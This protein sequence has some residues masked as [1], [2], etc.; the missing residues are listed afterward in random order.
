MKKILIFIFLFIL[1]TGL[2]F[3]A[4]VQVWTVPSGHHYTINKGGDYDIVVMTNHAIIQVYDRVGT[5]KNTYNAGESW[6]WVYS[7]KIWTFETEKYIYFI[8]VVKRDNGTAFPCH[9]G[10]M[11]LRYDKTNDTYQYINIWQTGGTTN[12]DWWLK[13][14][15]NNTQIIIE[16]GWLNWPRYFDFDL[17]TY[18]TYTW[19]TPLSPVEINW[20]Y[21]Y[22]ASLNQINYLDEINKEYV[23]YVSDTQGDYIEIR[24]QF[25]SATD[26]TGYTYLYNSD[27][28]T[29]SLSI[30]GEEVGGSLDML[31]A[32]NDYIGNWSIYDSAKFYIKQTQEGLLAVGFPDATYNYSH[33]Q[34]QLNFYPINIAGDDIL[35]FFND[36]WQIMKESDYILPLDPFPWTNWDS[37]TWTLVYDATIWDWDADGDGDVELLNWEI[38]VWIWKMFKYFFEKLLDFFANVR[39]LLEKLGEVFTSEEKTFSLIKTSYATENLSSIINNN[40]DENAYKETTLG[41]IDVFIKWFMAFLILV[42]GIAF[43]IWINRSKSD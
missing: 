24:N 17:G 14:R 28:G 25:I 36:L 5:L 8:N 23:Y 30:Y 32:Y 22:R 31:R 29:I 15:V 18:W 6:S 39:A 27:L 38:F 4:I 9:W 35:Y 2:A 11:S 34:H 21:I 1:S 26:F 3:G 42:I 12:C 13:S 10:V 16:G 19:I 40:V 20:N 41:K 7:N 43:F 37:G 33:T